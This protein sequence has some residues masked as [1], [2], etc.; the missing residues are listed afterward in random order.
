MRR[1]DAGVLRLVFIEGL[2]SARSGLEPSRRGV[3]ALRAFILH[4]YGLRHARTAC[5][6]EHHSS[7][8]CNLRARVKNL[9]YVECCMPRDGSA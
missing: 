5:E 7:L 6:G 2:L 3:S 8:I 9:G 1:M 4:T